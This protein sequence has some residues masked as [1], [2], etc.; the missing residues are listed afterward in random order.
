MEDRKTVEIPH[1]VAVWLNRAQH[2][3][4]DMFVLPLVQR[5]TLLFFF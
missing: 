4:H 5:Q 2:S 3:H 1:D